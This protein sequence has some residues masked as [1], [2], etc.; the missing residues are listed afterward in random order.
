MYLITA[1]AVT[2]KAQQ[3]GEKQI[4][5]MNDQFQDPQGPVSWQL[6]KRMK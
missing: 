1:A 6:S 2:G 5:F 4:E 3:K